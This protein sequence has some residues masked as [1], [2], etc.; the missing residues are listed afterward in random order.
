MSECCIKPNQP[1]HTT[2]LPI[3][4]GVLSLSLQ[5]YEWVLHKAQ[6]LDWSEDSAKALVVIGDCCPHPPSMT[7]QNCYWHTE[8]D[9]LRGMGVKVRALSLQE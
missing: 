6:Q 8:L 2:S 3:P 9:L 5:A 4:L 1:I 7:D